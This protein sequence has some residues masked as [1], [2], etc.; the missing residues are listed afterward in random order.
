MPITLLVVIVSALQV[1]VAGQRPYFETPPPGSGPTPMEPYG[2]SGGCSE[3]PAEFHRCAIAK[4]KEFNPPRTPD[5]CRTFRACGH[6]SQP[7]TWRT[8]KSI[9][10]DGW[11]RWEE[12]DSWTRRTAGPLP[13]LGSGEDA[14]SLHDLH[15]PSN[16][17]SSR[18]AAKHAYSAGSR[19]IVQTPGYVLVFGSFAH[20]YRVI[21]TDGRPHLPSDIHLFMGNSRGRWEGNTLVVDV[22]NLRDRTWFD[23]VG[24]FYS[25]MVHVVERWTMFDPDVNALRATID[26]PSVYTRP[27]TMA[28]GW[29]RN[30]EPGYEVW[31]NACWEGVSQ[32]PRFGEGRELYPGAARN[33]SYHE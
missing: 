5:V 12:P 4:A 11:F 19:Q 1:H 14:G 15:Q 21:P 18:R 24:N 25:D 30:S 10:G 16:A 8:S 13:A 3:E 9:R 22:T 2:E 23:H 26:D 20:T 32:G 17:L 7:G 28:L 33:N 27:W 29:R 6:E 31:E